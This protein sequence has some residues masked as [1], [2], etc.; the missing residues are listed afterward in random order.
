VVAKFGRK[1]SNFVN[2]DIPVITVIVIP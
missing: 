1:I 2:K